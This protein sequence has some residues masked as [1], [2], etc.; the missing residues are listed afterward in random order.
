MRRPRAPDTPPNRERLKGLRQDCSEDRASSQ[1]GR[2]RPR[3]STA[4]MRSQRERR[5]RRGR[6]EAPVPT[7]GTPAEA[8]AGDPASRRTRREPARRAHAFQ[9][10]TYPHLLPLL[11]A[12]VRTCSS[13]DPVLV[14]SETLS[15]FQPLPAEANGW[16]P[17]RPD[18][19]TIHGVFCRSRSSVVIHLCRAFSWSMTIM[20]D[21]FNANRQLR[22][23]LG[24]S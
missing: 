4:G 24:A 14:A 2:R 12:P 20:K 22:P 8:S 19:P 21:R 7:G 11:P 17:R 15:W 6:S 16:P 23:C 18:D 13:G 10:L 1:P 3:P 9:T 5:S